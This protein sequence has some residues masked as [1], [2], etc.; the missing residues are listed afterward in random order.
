MH[1]LSDLITN[2]IQGI[3]KI[4]KHS[5]RDNYEYLSIVKSMSTKLVTKERFTTNFR[6]QLF[7][8]PPN[9]EHDTKKAK[10]SFTGLKSLRPT[11]CSRA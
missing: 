1:I 9:L 10:E 3:N 7:L 2:L 4:K 11:Y 6:N 5:T 8:S